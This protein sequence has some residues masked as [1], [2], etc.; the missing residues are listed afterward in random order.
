MNLKDHPALRRLDDSPVDLNVAR[1]TWPAA[2]E[3]ASAQLF[4]HEPE[5]ATTGTLRGRQ[6]LFLW[7]PAVLV[8]PL[9]DDPKYEVAG[10]AALPPAL[11]EVREMLENVSGRA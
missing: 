11:D 1:E 10:A 4:G 6:G 3:E 5:R 9:L 2:F 7:I 8:H